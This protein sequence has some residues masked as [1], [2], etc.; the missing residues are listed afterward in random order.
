MAKKSQKQKLREAREDSLFWQR[1]HKGL[2]DAYN[3]AIAARDRNWAAIH[4]SEK[5]VSAQANK[6]AEQWRTI[7]ELNRKVGD[8]TSCNDAY[9]ELLKNNQEANEA[10]SAR[11]ESLKA[12]LEF[13][14]GQL[15]TALA[16]REALLDAM[17]TVRF[18]AEQKAQ[19]KR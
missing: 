11:I 4:E 3:Q 19:G 18:V 5:T 1:Q 14:K 17:A 2:Y 7:N 8:L 13:V 16:H 12:E 15:N 10:A 6:I 9:G